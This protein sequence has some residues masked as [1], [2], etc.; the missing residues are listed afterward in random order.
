M[1]HGPAFI[2]SSGQHIFLELMGG[3][4]MKKLLLTS[5]VILLGL[6]NV[7]LAGE[8][9]SASGAQQYFVNLADGDTVT[10]PFKVVFGLS[11]MGVASAGVEMANTGH[12]HILIDRAPLGMGE[13]GA[14]ELEDGI[15]SDE[16]HLHFGK[17]QTETVLE[18]KPGKHS[19]QLVLG[20][21]NHV[22]HNPAVFSKVITITVK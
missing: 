6:N 13:D 1:A 21:V 11:G 14:E 2:H 16:N 8:T 20:D 5:A 17:G 4:I 15:I 19:L 10:A 9:P 22:P 12:H 18:L 3:A 7:A